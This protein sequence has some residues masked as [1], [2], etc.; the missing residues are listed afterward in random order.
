VGKQHP[1]RNN[2]GAARL[3]VFLCVGVRE[4]SQQANLESHCASPLT[5]PG[6]LDLH[7]KAELDWYRSVVSSQRL[8][9]N[10]KWSHAF[11]KNGDGLERDIPRLAALHDVLPP[12]CLVR[13]PSWTPGGQAKVGSNNLSLKMAQYLSM[14]SSVPGTR[15]SR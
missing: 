10:I 2:L 8:Q 12:H 6:P 14:A 11:R 13:V 15:E 9:R 5:G 4:D 1:A 3:A 7:V